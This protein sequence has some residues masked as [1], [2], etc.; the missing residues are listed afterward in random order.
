MVYK[1]EDNSNEIKLG[2]NNYNNNYDGCYNH[3]VVVAL[4]IIQ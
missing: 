3:S 2:I 4:T 1:K